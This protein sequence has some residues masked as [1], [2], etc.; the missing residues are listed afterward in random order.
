MEKY[1][2]IIKSLEYKNKICDKFR[3]TSLC[4]KESY[5]EVLAELYKSRT[6]YLS[7]AFILQEFAEKEKL[8]IEDIK[9]IRENLEDIIIILNDAKTYHDMNIE[10]NNLIVRVNK[11][12]GEMISKIQYL[13]DAHIRFT[14]HI[15]TDKNYAFYVDTTIM[16]EVIEDLN[17]LLTE[18]EIDM[19]DRLETTLVNIAKLVGYTNILLPDDVLFIRP[20]KLLKDI[21]G[22]SN[23]IN[24]EFRNYY[25]LLFNNYYI[26]DHEHIV[27]DIEN[28]LEDN[29]LYKKGYIKTMGF[30]G[31]KREIENL[32]KFV[33]KLKS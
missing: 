31:I 25:K 15:S 29:D 7:K 3:N 18:G 22:L 4:L 8:E 24:E 26:N 5:K 6:K 30:F 11:K 19:E 32:K 17:K 16:N 1:I 23:T 12:T 14:D 13:E 10:L 33:N 28:L 9:D 21:Q 2:E 27:K 20:P